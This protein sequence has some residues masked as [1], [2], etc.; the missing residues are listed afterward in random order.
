[1][2]T[3]GTTL[4]KYKVPRR[5]ITGD[6]RMDAGIYSGIDISNPFPDMPKS[7]GDLVGSVN[8]AVG[9]ENK[10][11]TD[12]T[13]FRKNIAQ[14]LQSRPSTPF[15]TPSTAPV[16][17]AQGGLGAGPDGFSLVNVSKD[18][19]GD[20]DRINRSLLGRAASFQ[21]DYSAARSANA[22]T[23]SS[24]ADGS[25][26]DLQSANRSDAQSL[27]GKFRALQPLLNTQTSAQS[28]A[29]DRVYLGKDDPGSLAAELSANTQAAADAERRLSDRAIRNALF[30][31]RLGSAGGTGSGY[32]NA[33]VGDAVGRIAAETAA[34]TADRRRQDTAALLSAQE[35]NLGRTQDLN[36]TNVMRDRIPIDLRNDLLDREARQAA[37]RL[38]AIGQGVTIDQLT[39]ELS[40][41]GRQL[42]LSSQALQNYLASNFLGVR[43]EGENYPLFVSGAPGRPSPRSYYPDYTPGNDYIG[44][45]QP[46]QGATRTKADQLYYAQTGKW[47]DQDQ[48]LNDEL[49]AYYQQVANQQPRY[50]SAPKTPASGGGY[51][52]QPDGSYDI[53]GNFDYGSQDTFRNS[54]QLYYGGYD[55]DRTA[56]LQNYYEYPEDYDY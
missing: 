48:F 13:N 4:G 9:A 33:Q 40:T 44:G 49:Y 18:P 38:A 14:M 15:S 50:P 25:Y 27:I 30:Q 52:G 6:P 53:I 12:Y 32:V 24:L 55:A 10:A 34:R 56:D 46:R 26:R 54:P 47:P 5:P 36:V 42:G 35:R 43:K 39:D 21:P 1:M 8:Y 23:I 16:G 17:P 3:G 29:I 20:F 28:G 11:R 7:Y 22:D 2:A 19:S 45:Y 37:Q 51:I 31:A 41:V